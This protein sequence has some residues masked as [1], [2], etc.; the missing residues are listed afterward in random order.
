MKLESCRD[1]IV[2][3]RAIEM[4][5][6]LYRLTAEFPREEI[7]GLTSQLR[8]AAVSVASNIAEGYGRSSR[9]EYRQFLGIARGSNLEVQTQLV[10]ARGLDVGNAKKID[11]AEILLF[12]IGMSRPERAGPSC[13]LPTGYSLLPAL[14]ALPTPPTGSPSGS[15]MPQPLPA[16]DTA[17]SRAYPR[18]CLPSPPCR[19]RYPCPSR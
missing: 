19:S 14:R 11:D 18:C 15:S 7:Y 10:I 13:L 5:L 6:A 2:W 9:G 16:Q 4:T 17:R 1:L 3:K 12:E 8:R